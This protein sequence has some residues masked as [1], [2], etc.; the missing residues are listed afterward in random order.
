MIRTT[1]RAAACALTL[2]GTMVLSVAGARA[3]ALHQEPGQEQARPPITAGR[4]AA[5]YRQAAANSAASFKNFPLRG[6][7]ISELRPAKAPQPGDWTACI[8]TAEQAPGY[9]AVF[10]DDEI[11]I[12]RA[13]AIDRCAEGRYGPLPAVRNAVKPEQAAPA[14]RKDRAGSGKGRLFR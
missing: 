9:F 3:Q 13:V 4:I 11:V 14:G 5:T 6:A 7:Q 1:M 12:R 8:R 10:Y 2:C